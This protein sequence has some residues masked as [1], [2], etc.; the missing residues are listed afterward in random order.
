MAFNIYG[1]LYIYIY[2]A[3]NVS[4]LCAYGG[5]LCFR[6]LATMISYYYDQNLM[7]TM[8]LE[9]NMLERISVI[10]KCDVNIVTRRFY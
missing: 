5:Y 4:A 10:I 3:T 6:A 9:I 7:K 8:H 1:L 2:I